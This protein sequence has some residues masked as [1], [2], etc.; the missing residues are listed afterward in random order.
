MITHGYTARVVLLETD[1]AV[2]LLMAVV[3]YAAFHLIGQVVL[4]HTL[5]ERT[6]IGLRR[7]KNAHL[8]K[9]LARDALLE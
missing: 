9:S 8:V 3:R 5:V 1:H 6:P 2:P 7:V 4:G